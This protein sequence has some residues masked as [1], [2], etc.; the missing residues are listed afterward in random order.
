MN[1]L[2]STSEIVTGLVLTNKISPNAVRNELLFPPYNDVV[3]AIKE[4]M[5][6][7]EDLIL[8]FGIGSINPA[9]DAIKNL[10]G[11]SGADWLSIL[12]TSY[13]Q[14]QTGMKMEKIGKKLQRGEEVDPIEIRNLANQFGK[15]KTGRFRLSD[16]TGVEFPFL[17]TG[18]KAIDTHFGGI[19]EVG[20]IVIGGDSGSG[21]STFMRDFS[22]QFVK[23]HP[24]KKVAIYSLEM[25]AEEIVGRFRQPEGMEKQ[26]EDQIEINCDPMDIDAV[27]TDA[28]Q[29]EDLGLIMVD[30]WIWQSKA[31]SL[32]QR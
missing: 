25:F 6:E 5:N 24:K 22:K 13:N 31:K 19:P 26:Y 8:K 12:E 23:K 30:L 11:L 21:K 15:G 27:Y 3:K 16:A 20:L 28:A 29:I 4:G 32:N 14:H 18:W 1:T 10:N 7:P 9:L 2:Q 17:K